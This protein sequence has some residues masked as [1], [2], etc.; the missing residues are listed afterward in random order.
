MPHPSLLVVALL[1]TLL[2]ACGSG[3]RETM[4]PEDTVVGD[5]VTA[6][7]RVEERTNAALDAHREALDR[8]IRDSEDA[9]A[10]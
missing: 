8:Q 1:G 3:E 5:L 4:E 9:P 10:E 7:E 6:P 2:A